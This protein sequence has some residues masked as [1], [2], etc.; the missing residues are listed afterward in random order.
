[1]IVEFAH[2]GLHEK[3]SAFAKKSI[4][5]V[6]NFVKVID[7]YMT[8]HFIINENIAQNQLDIIVNMLKSWNIDVKVEKT[9]KSVAKISTLPFS[10]GLWEDY[11][12]DD[13][14]LRSKAWGTHKRTAQ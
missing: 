14:M 2:L 6:E 12:I 5:F 8:T 10:A 1:M 4:I 9:E 7:D 13:Q 3:N 11:D